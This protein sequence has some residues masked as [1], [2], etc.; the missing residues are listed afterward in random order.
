MGQTEGSIKL[1]LTFLGAWEDLA[2]E[3]ASR[4]RAKGWIA[5]RQGSGHQT[6]EPNNDY[7]ST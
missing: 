1:C 3:V 7:S 6:Y 5:L 2:E 4:M